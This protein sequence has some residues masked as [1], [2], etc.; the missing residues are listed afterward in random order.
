MKSYI[1][2]Y[3][4]YIDYP[5]LFAYLAL[6]IFGLIMIYSSSMAWSVNYYNDSPDRFY[7]QQLLNLAIA[8]PVFLLAA[9]FPY[10]HFKKKW[11]MATVLAVIFTGL[12]L[13]HFIGFAAGGAKSW[14]DL[15]FV[16][17]QPSEVAKVGLI[18]YLAGV[19]SNKYR[20][21]SI[22]KLNES[23]IPPVIILTAVLILVF[24]EPDLGS[25]VIIGAVG[26]SVMAASG[27]RLKPFVKLAGIVITATAVVIVP[28]MVFAQDLIFTEKRM[29]RIDAFFNPFSDELGFGFQIVNGYLAIGSGGLSGL[30]LGQ[31]IQ[32]LGYLPEPHTDFIMSVIAEELGVLGVFFVIGGLGFVVLRGLWIAMTTSDPLARMLA[33]G[34]ASMIGIQSF[35]NLGGLSGII[36][37]TGVTLPFISYGGTSVILLSLAMG[38]LMNVSMFNKYEKTKK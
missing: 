26:L 38:V 10:K 4:K 21:G 9:I 32:K 20:N 37:L 36:P 25:M 22:N 30:G 19:F 11:M 8:Y 23:I 24:F 34:V 15:G 31:S 6:T 3:G 29:G 16:N 35:V 27:V 1:K 14:I 5:L 12:I 33:A 17:I 2:K 13:V 28:M 18:F 7:I